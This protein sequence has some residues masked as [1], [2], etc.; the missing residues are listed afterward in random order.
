MKQKGVLETLDE[1]TNKILFQSTDTYKKNI[2]KKI[3]QIESVT[4]LKRI[5]LFI[6]SITD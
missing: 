5:L 1:E 6:Q 3:E 2:T 4:T